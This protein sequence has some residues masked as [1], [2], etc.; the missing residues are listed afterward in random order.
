MTNTTITTLVR[1]HPD[2]L[3]DLAHRLR[4]QAM[5]FAYPG[6]VVMVPL[7]HE[8]TL[9]YEPEETFCK[10]LTRVGYQATLPTGVEHVVE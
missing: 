7:T 1:V 4:S 9:M 10:P 3:A 6:E 5:D 8:I 2:T